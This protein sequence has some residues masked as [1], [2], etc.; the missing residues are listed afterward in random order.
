MGR[1]R[2]KTEGEVR[3]KLGKVVDSLAQG[4]VFVAR[5]RMVTAVLMDISD[6]FDL[7][8]EIEDLAELLRTMGGDCRC[9]EGD[10]LLDKAL[11][12]SAD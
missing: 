11:G 2:I 4:P 12:E 9:D 6:Y 5:K 7:V 8:R 10:R 1:I 3:R